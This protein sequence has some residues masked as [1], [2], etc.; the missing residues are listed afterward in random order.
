MLGIVIPAHNEEACLPS[1][2]A[3]LHV[4]ASHPALRGESVLIHVVLD[5]CDD[6]SEDALKRWQQRRLPCSP[7]RAGPRNTYRASRT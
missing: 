5:D 6:G 4:A 2:L 7:S 1:C 3:A